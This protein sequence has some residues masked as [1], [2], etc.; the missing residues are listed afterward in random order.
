LKKA[1]LRNAARL[2]DGLPALNLFGVLLIAFSEEKT[3]F[4]DMIADTRVVRTR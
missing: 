4:G 1:L 2:V 3:R